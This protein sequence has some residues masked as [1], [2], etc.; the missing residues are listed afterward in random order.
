MS[1]SLSI[2]YVSHL[3]PPAGRPLESLGGIQTVSMNL[4]GTFE[5]HPG[6]EVIPWVN[7]TPWRGI[8]WS[9]ARFLWKS[10][11]GLPRMIS[12]SQPDVVLF[13][14][15]V[16][17]SLSPWL[18]YR[19][20]RTPLISIS[21]GHDVT[22]DIRP[23]QR[24]L[25]RVFA[26]LDG[27]IS[28]SRATQQ[29]TL[30]RGLNPEK[31]FVVHNGIDPGYESHL[32]DYDQAM[33][34][35]PV[36]PNKPMLLTVGRLVKRKGHAWFLS[37][38]LPS[39][40]TPLQYVIIGEGPEEEEIHKLS[41]KINAEGHHRVIM[42]GR[43]DQDVLHAAYRVADLFVMPN[44]PVQGDMEGFG[45]VLLEAN[46]ASTPAIV[47]DL[48]GMKDVIEPGIN[49]FRIEAGNHQAFAGKIDEFIEPGKKASLSVLAEQSAQYVREHFFWNKI[50]EHYVDV[51]QITRKRTQSD[52]I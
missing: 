44:I 21:H 35:L 7:R 34:K 39:V 25:P 20:V 10:F 46:L 36:A 15:M 22:L 23:Y 47:S 52:S 6:L 43:Q 27:V 11:Q 13:T 2:L 40:K 42:M 51:I 8:E 1:D 48:E 37:E 26:N 16:T 24:Y 28:V 9:T 5:Q 49:G 41:D 31:S 14:S 3:H 29:E 50:V 33:Q 18:K 38:V 17:A 30:K 19:G 32:P 4:M 12:H 45:V